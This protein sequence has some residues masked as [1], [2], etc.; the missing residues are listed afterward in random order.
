MLLAD[1]PFDLLKENLRYQI[2]DPL[3]TNVNYIENAID[4]FRVL[5]ETY[6]EN[7]DAI[8]NINSLTV[9]FFAFIIKQIDEQFDLDIDVDFSDVQETVEVGEALYNFLILRYKKNITKFI[10]RFIK[11]NKKRLVEEFEGQ[12]KK[13]D[14]TSISLK[15]KIKNK[16]DV[17]IISNLPSIIKYIMN[18]EIEPLDFIEYATKSELYE[19]NYLSNMILQGKLIGNFVHEYVNLINEDYD[20]ILDEIQTDVKMKLMN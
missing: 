13:K 10:Y 15:K 20:Y 14:V 11:K 5:R 7:A 8:R 12:Y 1:L 16:D 2:K 3:A 6:S 19:G 17:L 18:L 4:K 9:N